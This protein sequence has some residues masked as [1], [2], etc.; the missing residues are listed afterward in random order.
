MLRKIWVPI[1]LV[2]LCYSQA[3]A[4]NTDHLTAINSVWAK[5]YNAFETLDYTLMAEIH[6]K[7]LVRVSGGNR[8]LDYD[9]YINNY[10]A[11]FERDKKAGQTSN[12]SL[13]FFERLCDG[14]T[15][16]ERGIYRLVR[17]KDTD[18]EQSYYGQFHVIMKKI[19]GEWKITMDYD[20]SESDTIGEDDYNKAFAIDDF[21]KF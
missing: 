2:V 10:K 9:T 1:L 6:S 8:I 5:F 18:N 3:K 16:S 19:D 14:N 17:N 7:D 12:I 21:D 20:S 13:R 11:G 15:S 4:Q